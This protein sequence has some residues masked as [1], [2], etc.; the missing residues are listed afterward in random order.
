MEDINQ[1]LS[2]ELLEDI[3]MQLKASNLSNLLRRKYNTKH[4]YVYYGIN[5]AVICYS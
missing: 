3:F 1:F 2:T 5:M 4:E